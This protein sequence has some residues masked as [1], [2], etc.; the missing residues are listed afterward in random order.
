MSPYTTKTLVSLNKK[1][2][3]EHYREIQTSK[4]LLIDIIFVI[5][6]NSDVLFGDALYALYVSITQRCAVPFVSY[7]ENELL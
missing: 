3:F 7:K 5:K 2:H 1:T 6:K 4:H